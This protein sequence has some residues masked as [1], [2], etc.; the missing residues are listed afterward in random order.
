MKYVVMTTVMHGS[1]MSPAQSSSSSPVWG[2][3]APLTPTTRTITTISRLLTLKPGSPGHQDHR[4]VSADYQHNW[5][6][7]A[8]WVCVVTPHHHHHHRTLRWFAAHGGAAAAPHGAEL[9]LDWESSLCWNTTNTT[10]RPF[11]SSI[12]ASRAL[13]LL[14]LLESRCSDTRPTGI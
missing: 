14:I 9:E 12:H 13:C 5:Q 3:I 6:L 1:S 11:L 8:E 4:R 7:S 2:L 10:V